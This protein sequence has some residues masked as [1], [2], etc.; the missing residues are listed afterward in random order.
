MLPTVVKILFGAGA[1]GMI[2]GWW[3]FLR[4]AIE[5]NRALPPQKRFLMLELRMHSNE[6]K[7]L[8]EE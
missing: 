6:A 3:L 7:R 5:L 1:I 2:V 4:M 8:Q